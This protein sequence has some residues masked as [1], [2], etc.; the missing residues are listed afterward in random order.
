MAYVDHLGWV[1]C[2]CEDGIDEDGVG[3]GAI[4]LGGSGFFDGDVR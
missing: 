3:A 1:A 4:I 2:F